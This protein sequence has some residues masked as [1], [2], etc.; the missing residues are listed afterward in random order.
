MKKVCRK[1]GKV[2]FDSHEKAAVRAGEILVKCGDIQF[3]RTY[4]C[5][6]CSKWHLTSSGHRSQF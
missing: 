3:L 6:D 2:K 1:S 5:P 4:L